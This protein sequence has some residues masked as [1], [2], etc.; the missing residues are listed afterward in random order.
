M[1]SVPSSPRSGEADVEQQLQSI[2]EAIFLPSA[3]I[4]TISDA[5]TKLMTIYSRADELTCLLG[6]QRR[7][8]A[9]EAELDRSL[10]L[11]DLCDAMQH[12][13]ADLKA[14]IQEMQLAGR[15]GDGA[16][17]QAMVQSY[18]VVRAAKKAQRHFRRIG[19]SKAAASDMQ[20]CRVLRLLAEA[21]ETAVAALETATKLLSKQIATLPSSS[22]WSQLVTRKK[23]V[24]YEQEQLQVLELDI[25]GLEHGVELL[26]RRL[27]Q[28]RVSLLNTLTL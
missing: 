15:R 21:R 10:V 16:A 25:A 14:T 7:R 8:A 17:V 20:T 24:A 11:L 12:C 22:K 2:K 23:S 13:F 6:G 3:T 5:L 28:S 1:A 26:F 27:I 19:S 18:Y 9:A 4:Q